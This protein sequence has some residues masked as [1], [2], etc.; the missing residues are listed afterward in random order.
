MEAK[1]KESER[2]RLCYSFSFV[3]EKKEWKRRR[4]DGKE[5]KEG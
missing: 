3:M 5:R 1:R 4:E 2:N